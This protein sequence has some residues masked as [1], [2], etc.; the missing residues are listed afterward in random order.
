MMMMMVPVMMIL[1]LLL[2]LLLVAL[3]NYPGIAITHFIGKCDYDMIN[4]SSFMDECHLHIHHSC[5]PAFGCRLLFV[6]IEWMRRMK[7]MC[8]WH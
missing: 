6:H 5:H 1:L 8:P 4:V 7:I 3:V 2:L